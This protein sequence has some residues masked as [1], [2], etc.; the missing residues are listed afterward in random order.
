MTSASTAISLLTHLECTRCGQTLDADTL[1]TLCPADGGVL[2][3]RYDLEQ[4]RTLLDRADMA[5]RAP[6]MWQIPELLP[7]RDR[8]NIVSLGEGGT[9]LLPVPRLGERL[10]FRALSIKDEG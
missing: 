7:V 4:A 1:Q 5:Q 6:G 2:Y 9:P 8:A 3:A 10:G